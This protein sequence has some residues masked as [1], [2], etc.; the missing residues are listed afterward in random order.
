SRRGSATRPLVVQ[1]DLTIAAGLRCALLAAALARL[2]AARC[3][4][5]TEAPD[6]ETAS[7]ERCQLLVCPR[8]RLLVRR[9]VLERPPGS[10]RRNP[11]IAPAQVAEFTHLLPGPGERLLG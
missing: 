11:S 5:L 4:T 3:A 2:P 9:T 10:D 1:N 6:T 8:K 7:A